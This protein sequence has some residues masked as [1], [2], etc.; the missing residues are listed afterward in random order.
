VAV[1][2]GFRRHVRTGPAL[3]IVPLPVA[4]LTLSTALHAIFIV[5]AV[6]AVKALHEN[7]PTAYFVNL[8][9][10]VPA[11]GSPQG[12]RSTPRPAPEVPTKAPPLP[13]RSAPEAPTKT[14]ELPA[15]SAKAPELPAREATPPAPRELP[16]RD[17]PPRPPDSLSLPERP[18]PPRPTPLTS[19]P[20]QKELPTV[21]SRSSTSPVTPPTSPATTRDVGSAPPP[22]PAGLPSGSAQGAGKVTLDVDFPYAWYLRVLVGKINERWDGR[23]LPGN[24]PIVAFEID[25]GGQVNLSKVKVERSSGNAAYDQMAVRSILES[26]PFPPL[27]D[28]FK[29]DYLTVHIQFDYSRGG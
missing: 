21:A 25:R 12:V 28:D 8:V 20:E 9:P 26:N 1:A 3:R 22:P 18:L 13:T 23:A 7:Q 15:R 24:Q 4:G 10:A 19:R 14:P 6:I 2:L 11:V 16:P 5:A 29:A 27:P 17:L